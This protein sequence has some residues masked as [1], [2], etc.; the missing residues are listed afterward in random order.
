MVKL[1]YMVFERMGKMD[2]ITEHLVHKDIDRKDKAKKAGIVAAAVVLC[3]VA[4]RF[5][6]SFGLFGCAVIIYI[7]YK[8]TMVTDVE[9]EYCLINGDMDIDRIFSRSRRKR[10]ISFEAVDVEIVAPAESSRLKEFEHHKPKL[11][12]AAKN[13]REPGNYA[14]IA[15]TPK[16][17]A[18][19]IIDGDEKIVTQL[20]KF[21]PRKVFED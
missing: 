12:F 2:S 19:I 11:Y 16:G 7:A 13:M 14:I 4:F 21:M 20:R 1:A 9:F 10:Y 3:I 15:N 5:L 18:K 6:G 17:K 8:L